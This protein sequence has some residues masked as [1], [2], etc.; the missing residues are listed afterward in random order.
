MIEAHD[1]GH[2]YRPERWLLRH[3]SVKFHPGTITAL[4]G[5]NGSGKTTF[6]RCLCGVLRPREGYV[7]AHGVIGYVPQALQADHAYRAIDMVLLGRSRNIGRFGAPGSADVKRALECLNNVGLASQAYVRYD[8]MSGGQRQLVLLARALATDCRTLVLDEPASALDLA[9]AGVV[10]RL[11]RRLATEQNIAVLFTTHQPDHALGVA[12]NALL[13]LN[14]AA[15]VYGAVEETMN[16]TNLAK[17]YGIPIRRLSL[18]NEDETF[19]TA[20]PLHRFNA[21]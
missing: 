11:L 5:V 3:I 18:R 10:L 12:D 7:S 14:D 1:I 21:Q 2:W 20:I 15:H 13:L 8:Q 16:E 4:L 17:L 19:E 9:N 6:L